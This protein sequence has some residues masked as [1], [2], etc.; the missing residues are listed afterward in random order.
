[1]SPYTDIAPNS[2]PDSVRKGH[3]G[4]DSRAETLSRAA[5]RAIDAVEAAVRALIER[6]RADR[7]RR[8]TIRE[9]SALNDH[10]LRDIGLHR[11]QIRSVAHA[12]AAGEES[13]RGADFLRIRP[14]ATPARPRRA[15]N[16]NARDSLQSQCRAASSPC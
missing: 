14:L 16:D 3:F 8:L 15:A 10:N 13:S 1:M 6:L 11:S 12:L 4:A 7:R 2:G 5:Y 9:L